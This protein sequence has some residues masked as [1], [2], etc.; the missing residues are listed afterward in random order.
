MIRP[1]AAIACLCI[2]FVSSFTFDDVPPEFRELL[3][4]DV[5]QFVNSLTPEDK[6]IL[7]EVA[8]K[9]G[10]E[11][12]SDEAGIAAVKAKSPQLGDKLQKIYDEIQQKLNALS[13]EARAFAKEMYD[14][15]RKL[16]ADHVAGRKPSIVEI[17]DLTQKAIDRYKALPKAAQDDLK[18]Q[19]P[20]LVHA[21]TSK[22]FHKMV[23]RMLINN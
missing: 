5:K 17:T 8:K 15:T 10:E 18:K 12:L 22:K 23:A 2:A 9:Y 11:K 14:I 13:P 19:F 20:T 1:V 7:E 4:E 16:H 21:F 6:K 3:P